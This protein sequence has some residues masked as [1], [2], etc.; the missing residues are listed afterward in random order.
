MNKKKVVKTKEI[1]PKK[2][3][4]VVNKKLLKED[5]SFAIIE[6]C[7]T[8]IEVYPKT[9][10]VIPFAKKLEKEQIIIF[11]KVLATD[12]EIGNPY[13]ENW[14]VVAKCLEPIV[15][16]KKIIVFKYKAKKNYRV[17]T[18][19]RQKW[20]LFIVEEFQSKKKN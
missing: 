3:K 13:L 14:K 6:Y 17:K 12:K 8:Q 1:T 5:L 10:F 11:D 20:S 9:K 19:H 16:D 18:G 7:Q 15:K 2:P 4:K